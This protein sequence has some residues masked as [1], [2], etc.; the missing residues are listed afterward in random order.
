MSLSYMEKDEK[1]YGGEEAIVNVVAAGDLEAGDVEDNKIDVHTNLC[2]SLTTRLLTSA[3][4]DHRRW[5][6][7]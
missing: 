3:E 5:G 7:T 6:T 4:C 1:T 2:E